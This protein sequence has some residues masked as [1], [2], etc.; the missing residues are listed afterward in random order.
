M[1]D[2]PHRSLPMRK[3][4]KKL[5]ELADT[6]AYGV[7]EIT[8]AVIRALASD[9]R[10]EVG[11]DLLAKL[12]RSLDDKGQ[13]SLFAQQLSSD[14]EVLKSSAAGR[15]LALTLLEC[16]R[17]AAAAGLIGDAALEKAANRALQMGVTRGLRQTEEHYLRKTNAPRAASVRER[18]EMAASNCDM[19]VLGR[20]LTGLEPVQKPGKA[21]K[22][23]GIHEGV[24]L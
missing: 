12:R 24:P 3:Q 16:A 22:R 18:G 1:S 15:P 17:H 4:W 20:Q 19:S 7:A 6:P 9:W 10:E 8:E 14:L 11:Q 23:S 2:G 5:A 21:N 13:P